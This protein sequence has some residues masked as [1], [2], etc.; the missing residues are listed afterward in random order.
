MAKEKLQLFPP[1]RAAEKAPSWKP[2]ISQGTDREMGKV[3]DHETRGLMG[4]NDNN[5]NN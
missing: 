2:C 4:S 1:L 5:T 3:V